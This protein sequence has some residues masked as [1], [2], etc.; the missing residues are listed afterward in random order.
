MPHWPRRTR[1]I[2]GQRSSLPSARRHPGR[3]CPRVAPARTRQRRLTTTRS[4]RL[5]WRPPSLWAREPRSRRRCRRIHRQACLP[6]APALH[7]PLRPHARVHRRPHQMLL[8]RCR[9]RRMGGGRPIYRWRRLHPGPLRRTVMPAEPERAGL[10][11]KVA[12]ARTHRL[13][14][15]RAQPRS[16]RRDRARPLSARRR[17]QCLD[18]RRA[19]IFPC[20]GN[21][22][23][24]TRWPGLRALPPPVTVASRSRRPRGPG[25]HVSSLPR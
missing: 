1:R 7:P 21:W 8:R 16:H 17:R 15:R 9:A 4:P 13:S 11:K 24:L 5:A 12:P 6:G 19:A 18:S 3:P 10:G 23:R 2:V 25:W 22:L 20:P 14:L